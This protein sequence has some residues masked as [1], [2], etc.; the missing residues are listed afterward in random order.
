M[1]SIW[2]GSAGVKGR[3]GADAG[4]PVLLSDNTHV[5]LK[6]VAKYS[7]GI[8]KIFKKKFC[9]PAP[10][11]QGQHRQAGAAGYASSLGVLDWHSWKG[12][13]S[14]GLVSA[15]MARFLLRAGARVIL[16][17]V[18]G[19]SAGLS[20]VDFRLEYI[21]CEWLDIPPAAHI[22]TSCAAGLDAPQWEV[23][24]KWYEIVLWMAGTMVLLNL[25]MV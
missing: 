21:S 19:D 13:L 20:F 22:M 7:G 15:R 1:C 23:R 12:L 10:H 5:I 6:L 18:V 11:T 16:S 8:S 14:L 17:S 2:R 3:G 9:P 24:M 4:S 25:A